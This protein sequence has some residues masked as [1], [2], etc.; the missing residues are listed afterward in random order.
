VCHNDSR[1]GYW[2]GKDCAICQE[3]WDQPECTSCDLTHVGE[4]CGVLCY[5]EHAHYGDPRDVG[6]EKLPVIPTL[7]CITN[8]SHEYI[9]AWFGYH[10][11]N[12]H[13]VY[14]D[15]GPLNFFSAPTPSIQP[16]GELGFLEISS[17]STGTKY[18]VVE[19]DLGQ[20]R[21]FLPGEYNKV[22]SVKYVFT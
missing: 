19:K 9:L 13:N 17:G 1:L 7:N 6:S 2:K 15:P 14:L 4:D 3:G 5:T 22:F 21:K 20:E 12:P 8:Q 18:P 11:K 16:G 10:N